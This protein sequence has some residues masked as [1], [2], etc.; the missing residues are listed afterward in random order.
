[1]K[2]CSKC[3]EVKPL[4]E[5]SACKGYRDGHKNWCKPCVVKQSAVWAS[6]NKNKRSA[7]SKKH[8]SVRREFYSQKFNEWY[9]KNHDKII[10]YRKKN[11]NLRNATQAARR[12]RKLQATP[13]WV[14]KAERDQ[15][16]AMYAEAERLSRETGVLH[17]VDHIYPLKGK[18]VSGLHVFENLQILKYVDNI[19]KSNKH[20]D[21]VGVAA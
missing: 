7:S 15:I 21:E 5:F 10:E 20:P 16:R 2:M 3:L 8:K 18:N 12:S 19:K 11:R 13:R 14:G 4:T 1:M 17:H 6:S 9:L